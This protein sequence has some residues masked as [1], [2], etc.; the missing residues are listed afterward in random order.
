[1]FGLRDMPT[2]AGDPG[3]T[4]VLAPGSLEPTEHV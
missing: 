2:A 1:M 3:W 4:D